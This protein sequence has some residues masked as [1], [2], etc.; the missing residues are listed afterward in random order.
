MTLSVVSAYNEGSGKRTKT[1]AGS[2]SYV[3]KDT[4]DSRGFPYNLHPRLDV[5]RFLLKG[6][7]GGLGYGVVCGLRG[8]GRG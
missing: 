4:S 6:L 2:K 5:E 3:P 8:V 7:I 1:R